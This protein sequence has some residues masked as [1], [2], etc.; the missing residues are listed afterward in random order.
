MR[1]L[2]VGNF[3]SS[4]IMGI[5][6]SCPSLWFSG[7]LVETREI[8]LKQSLGAIHRDAENAIYCIRSKSHHAYFFQT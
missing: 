4:E 1:N 8:M 5:L 7:F 2:P 3:G 6:F